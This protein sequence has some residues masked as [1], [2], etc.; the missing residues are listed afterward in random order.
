MAELAQAY[1]PYILLIMLGICMV[2]KY[3][4]IRV[5]YTADGSYILHEGVTHL[6][7]IPSCFFSCMI[8]SLT[9]IVLRCLSPNTVFV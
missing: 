9:V 8:L 1:R 3:L 6:H 5:E 4:I 2:L 7:V